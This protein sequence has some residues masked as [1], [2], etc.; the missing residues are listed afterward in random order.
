MVIAADGMWS[1]MRKLLAPSE[2]GYLGEWHAFRQ[3]FCDVG[4][5][6][7]TQLWVWFDPD[8]LPGY[9]WSFPLGDGRANVGFGIPRDGT[10][11]TQAMKQLWPDILSRPHVRGVLGE[12]AIAEAPH[13]AWPIPA[14]IGSLPLHAG[15]ALF[16]GDAAGATDRLTG[17]GIGQALLTG[18]LAAE[19]IIDHGLDD[20]AGA[21]GRYERDVR[22]ELVADHRMSVALGRIL[23]H[24]NGARGAIRVAGMSGWTR[25]N[26]ARWLFEDEPRAI[27]VTPRRWHRRFLDRDGAF[28]AE[29]ARPRHSPRRHR[30][31]TRP[32]YPEA[33]NEPRRSRGV[34]SRPRPVTSLVPP[35]R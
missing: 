15:R 20:P 34:C 18:Q 9:A 3:Y 26:F 11:A 4:P 35:G 23:E 6:A 5:A 14:R 13:K 10:I 22:R 28:Q 30:A 16:V 27:V 19:A 29:P 17:E 21:A 24:P 32:P 25:R 31:E 1:P 8:L 12:N 33:C 7:A 2:P